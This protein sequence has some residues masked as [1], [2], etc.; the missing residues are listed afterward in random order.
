MKRYT[1]GRKKERQTD[2]QILCELKQ[3]EKE[4]ERD[5]REVRQTDRWRY[6]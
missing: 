3:T 1:R 5:L 4:R 6:L 2:R